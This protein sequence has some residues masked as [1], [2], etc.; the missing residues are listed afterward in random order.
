MEKGGHVM[1]A[2]H[3]MHTSALKNFGVNPDY[4]QQTDIG[5]K[6]RA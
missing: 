2:M 4:K 1:H 5:L 3:T 6:D